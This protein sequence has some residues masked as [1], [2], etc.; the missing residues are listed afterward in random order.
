MPLSHKKLSAWHHLLAQQLEAG[1]T[2]PTALRATA[3]TGAPAATLD[4][5]AKT[6]EHG[7]SIDDALRLTRDWLPVSDALFLSAAAPSGRLPRVLRNLSE[8]HAQFSAVKT[9]LLLACLYPLA[10]LHL[11]LL[12]FPLV[13]MID[14]EKGFLWDPAA[15]VR[16]LALGLLPLWLIAAAIWYLAARESPLLHRLAQLLPAVRGYTRAQSLA[17][18]AFTLGNFLEAG[19]RIDPAWQVAGSL[20]RSPALQAAARD[21]DAVIASGQPPGP[22]LAH[23][24]CFPADFVALYQT[25]ESTGQ[26]EQNLLRLAALNQERA[27]HALK[28]ASLLYPS[29]LLVAT[30]VFIGYQ[31]VTFYAGYFKMIESLATP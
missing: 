8:R 22:R 2:L 10:I 6:I 1:L 20:N 21:I 28:V 3:G 19:L 14:W 5:M 25:G 24:P 30:V 7:G 13:R 26:L 9:R 11:G 15:Y 4:A 29:L 31:V 12:L 17:D 18:F 27:N 23:F 16:A